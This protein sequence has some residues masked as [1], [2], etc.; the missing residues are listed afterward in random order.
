MM[1]KPDG[2]RVFAEAKG[3]QTSD[4]RIKRRLWIHNRT[5]LLEV[6]MGSASRPFL[7]ETLG[8]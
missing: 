5:E 6:W 8:G 7:S 1:I 3:Y 4:Y 2:S